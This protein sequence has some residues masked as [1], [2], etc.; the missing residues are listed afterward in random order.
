MHKQ[1]RNKDPEKRDD[2][3]IGRKEGKMMEEGAS[4]NLLP[5]I[6]QS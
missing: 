4:R 6:G 2:I 5:T 3:V 1:A